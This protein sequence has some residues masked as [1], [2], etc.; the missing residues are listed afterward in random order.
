MLKK[1]FQNQMGKTMYKIFLSFFITCNAF[2]WG[3]HGHRIVA[4]IAENNLSFNARKEVAKILGPEED[5]AMA[6]TWADFIKSDFNRSKTFPWHYVSIDDPKK[7]YEGSPKSPFKDIIWAIDH[8]QKQL[9]DKKLDIETRREAL[10]FLIHFVGDIHQP[11][12]V[13][14]TN[15]KGGNT[16]EMKWFG[17]N[18]NL[19]EI[20]DEKIIELQK[21]S[22]TEYVAFI[23][24]SPKD[25]IKT[26]KT[27]DVLT[28]ANESMELRPLVYDIPKKQEKYWEYQYSYKTL[29]VLN[30]RLE[31]A[32]HRLALILNSL[33]D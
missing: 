2:A 4:K 25:I 5:M 3:P 18:T 9:K 8:F 27:K 15:D 7:G 11:L 23:A 33:F 12:H 10:R 29:K 31:K 28:W 14:Y 19:H 21:L 20:W 24:R 1:N 22:Y 6:S 13:G 30:E 17:V 32:G 16:I 26:W